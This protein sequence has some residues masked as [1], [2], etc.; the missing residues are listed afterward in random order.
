MHLIFLGPPGSGRGTQATL[1]AQQWQIPLISTGA[2]VRAA[3]A[4]HTLLGVQAYTY[5]ATGARVPD[6]LIMQLIHERFEQC[7]IKNGWIL[8]GVPRTLTQAFALNEWFRWVEQSPPT[9]IY[10]EAPI[11]LL[12]ERLLKRGN[13]E[14]TPLTIQQRLAAYY[15]ET[16]PLVELYRQRG[17][18]LVVDAAPSVPAVAQGLMTLLAGSG[19]G[20][21]PA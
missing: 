20:S 6:R 19:W 4:Q 1:L 13:P 21:Q 10:L 5:V 15:E 9:V 8:E 3:I 17:Q 2:L 16:L 14:D 12:M 7:D 18:L 11:L